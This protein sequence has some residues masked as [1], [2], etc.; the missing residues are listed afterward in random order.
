MTHVHP[1]AF[2]A[3]IGA[4]GQTVT[5]T[6][7]VCRVGP[8]GGRARW[9][10]DGSPRVRRPRQPRPAAGA[11][12]G[13]LPVANAG[14]TLDNPDREGPTTDMPVPEPTPALPQTPVD[15]TPPVSP[16][17][18]DGHYSDRDP[19]PVDWGG[20]GWTPGTVLYHGDG[21]F[22]STI[23][24]L[25]PD[26]RIDMGGGEPLA[27]QLGTLASEVTVGATHPREL[28]GR[29]RTIRDR[30]PAGSRARNAVTA[31]LDQVDHPA[32]A[33]PSA[34]LPAGAP[35]P[36]RQLI[37]D[38]HDIP[39]CRKDPRET[40]ALTELAGR[41]ADRKASRREIRDTLGRLARLRHESYS[42]SGR[43]QIARLIAGAE[44]PLLDWYRNR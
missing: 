40:T 15:Q 3:P 12:L 21:P 18:V 34:T 6:G 32:T 41:L 7:M 31:L 23:R 25:G 26:A 24:D 10:S 29:L 9:G 33:S 35:A 20:F 2:C 38:L 8:A 36:L 22:G 37:D 27:D 28:G 17:L 13:G 14:I 43:Q 1:G 11:N 5:G 4:T 44:Q 30:L 39:L 16:D 19:L 42:D